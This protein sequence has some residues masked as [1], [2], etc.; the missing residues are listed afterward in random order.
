MTDEFL[1]ELY[2]TA[3]NRTAPGGNKEGAKRGSMNKHLA[4]LQAV[5][6]YYSSARPGGGQRMNFKKPKLDATFDLFAAEVMRRC[7]DDYAMCSPELKS[8][9]ENVAILQ[10]ISPRPEARLTWEPSEAEDRPG[11][12]LTAM[13]GGYVYAI[14]ERNKDDI[15]WKVWRLMLPELPPQPQEE[16]P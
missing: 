3:Y 14:D 10:E 1:K 5:R 4:G 7:M 2:L 15:S 6:D 11:A 16:K 8:I 9:L 13:P 12:F